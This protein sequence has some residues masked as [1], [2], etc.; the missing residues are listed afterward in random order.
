MTEMA[1]RSLIYFVYR[2]VR[3]LDDSSF[4]MYSNV[5]LINNKKIS[6]ILTELS[7]EIERVNYVVVGIGMNVKN[8]KFDG[9]LENISSTPF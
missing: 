9:E 2:T 1:F 4:S 7:A 3:I 6:G 8:T 5:L